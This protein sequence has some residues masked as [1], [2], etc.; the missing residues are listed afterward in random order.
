MF[1]KKRKEKQIDAQIKRAIGL[2]DKKTVIKPGVPDLIVKKG[3]G[4]RTPKQY[5]LQRINEV[6]SPMTVDVKIAG[7]MLVS[8]DLSDSSQAMMGY[9]LTA[10]GRMTTSPTFLVP[11]E[12][13]E[14]IDEVRRIAETFG[15][16]IKD[17]SD[18]KET[19]K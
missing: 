16:I 15:G 12:C 14:H 13:F 3:F 7:P 10:R 1:G 4:K 8:A 17:S 2:L 18:R 11:E 9:I 6:V 5:L 19:F